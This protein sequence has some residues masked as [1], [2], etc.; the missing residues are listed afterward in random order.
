MGRSSCSRLKRS[1][2][3]KRSA[4][5]SPG[6]RRQSARGRRQHERRAIQQEGGGVVGLDFPGVTREDSFGTPLQAA[7]LFAQGLHLATKQ[8]SIIGNCANSQTAI[9]IIAC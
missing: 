8:A 2:S 3:K 1:P 9:R 4:R 6:K 7:R 5:V